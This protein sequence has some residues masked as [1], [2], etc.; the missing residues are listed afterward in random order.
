[1]WYALLA[2]SATPRPIVRKINE[3][4][5]RA[6]NSPDVRDRLAAMGIDA[7][8]GTTEKFATFLKSEMRKWAKVAK[9]ANIRVD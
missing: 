5:D 3:S 6:L 9:D 7:L 2:P 8:G 4:F 1:V